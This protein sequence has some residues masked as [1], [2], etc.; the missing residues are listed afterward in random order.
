MNS[1]VLGRVAREGKIIQVDDV[2]VDPDYGLVGFAK[3]TGIRT[4]LGVPL[5][6]EIKP[7]GVMGL[8]RRAV[9]PFTEPQIKLA[10]SFADQ[11]VIAIENV[12]PVR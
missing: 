5:L 11:A 6:R 9:R 7:I 3:R 4:V 10:T 8:A 2:L 12:Q 1:G